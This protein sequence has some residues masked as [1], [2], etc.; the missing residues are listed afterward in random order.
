MIT[1]EMVE[2]AAK[3][4][5]KDRCS[6]LMWPDKSDPEYR[7]ITHTYLSSARA[8][9]E[10]AEKVR[11]APDIDDPTPAMIDAGLLE[12]VSF[13]DDYDH[14]KDCVHNIFIAMMEAAEEGRPSPT[15]C[16]RI[17]LKM[18]LAAQRRRDQT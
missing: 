2:A 3:A 13:N 5:A 4:I 18:L 12:F 11:A 7:Q 10:A 16:Q 15:S 14:P 9:L 6:G 17:F 1:D 8:A